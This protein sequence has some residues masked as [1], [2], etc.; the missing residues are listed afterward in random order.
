MTVNGTNGLAS[1]G[2]YDG[3]IGHGIQVIDEN[4]D[5]TLVPSMLNITPIPRLR[6]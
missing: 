6:L 3:E 2:D 5:F 1:N 4:K